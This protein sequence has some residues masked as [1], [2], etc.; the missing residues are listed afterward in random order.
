MKL[1]VVVLSLIISIFMTLVTCSDSSNQKKDIILITVD[2]TRADA[3]GCYGNKRVHTPVLDSLAATGNRFGNCISQASITLPSHTSILTGKIPP[4]HGVHNNSTYRLSEDVPLISEYF[5]KAGYQTGAF[6]GSIMLLKDYGLNRG[7]DIY[8]D[9]IIHYKENKNKKAI[10]TRRAGET[11]NRTW[12]WLKKQMGPTFTWIHFYDPHW[13]YEPPEPFKEAYADNPYFGEIAYVDLQIGKLIKQL[14]DQG[15][16]ENT[17][18]VVTADHGES[19]GEHGE[20]THG[21]FCYRSTTHVP[22]IFSKPLFKSRGSVVNR[23]VCST[24]IM[25]TLL[26][27]ADLHVPEDIEG[28]SLYRSEE[29][30]AYSETY[31]PFESFYL[32]PLASLQTD[33]HSFYHSSIDKFYDLT[34]DPGELEDMSANSEDP[35]LISLRDIMQDIEENANQNS[36][37]I[38]L[39]QEMIEM[40]AGLGY[41]QGGGTYMDDTGDPYLLPSP[42]ESVEL[43]RVIQ[44]NRQFEMQFPFKVIEALEDLKDKYSDHIMLYKELGIVYSQFGKPEKAIEYFEK[45]IAQRP[46]DPR[47]HNFLAQALF[48]AKRY[49]ESL[50]E[51]EMALELNDKQVVALY[52][53]ARV[54]IEL[55]QFDRAEKMLKAVLEI[56]PDDIY[57]LNNL[58]YIELE[59]HDDP[60]EA[61]KWMNEARKHN[62][63][64][65]LVKR[66]YQLIFNRAN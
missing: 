13:P 46:K 64:H 43:Y 56:K 38:Q 20:R 9:D 39:D 52:N 50:A 62:S 17:L 7:F 30:I 58:A 28:V 41:V 4:N 27:Y 35:E 37:N 3:I 16:W 54:L 19:F 24:D 47:L 18:L 29:R 53:I 55:G 45:V 51:F 23:L 59:F 14:K 44:I 21:F 57:A 31:I 60:K 26:E 25:P 6:I 36:E 42:L 65:P 22:L 40:L 66:N 15:R 10:I 2:T 32:S 5:K 61:L 8:D 11:I 33:T 48:V 34:N 1:K 63:K 49:E 12:Q